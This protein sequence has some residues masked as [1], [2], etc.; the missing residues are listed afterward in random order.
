MKTANRLGIS[1]VMCEPDNFAGTTYITEHYEELLN[2]ATKLLGGNQYAGDLLNDV[3]ISIKRNEDN[4]EGWDPNKSKFKEFYTAAQWVKSRMVRYS[5]NEAYH[6]NG[7]EEV[8]VGMVGDEEAEEDSAY[9]A[10]QQAY[11]NAASYDDL[12]LIELEESVM[13]ELKYLINFESDNGVS[14]R[15][16]FQIIQDGGIENIDTRILDGIKNMGEDIMEALHDILSFAVQSKERF[17]VMLQAAL[18]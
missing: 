8:T 5:K 6:S 3:Y 2:Y 9:S 1:N 18:A 15:G 4:G 12:E 14:F 17:D 13:E 7:R 10:I 11:A 16:L